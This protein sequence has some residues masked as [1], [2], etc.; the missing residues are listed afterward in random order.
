[1]A[2]RP[3]TRMPAKISR[4]TWAPRED[5]FL[6]SIWTGCGTRCTRARPCPGNAKITL[7]PSLVSLTRAPETGWSDLSLR[8]SGSGF[9]RINRRACTNARSIRARSTR[10]TRPPSVVS[11]SSAPEIGSFMLSMAST[12]DGRRRVHCRSLAGRQHATRRLPRFGWKATPRSAHGSS[13]HPPSQAPQPWQAPLS[14]RP[15]QRIRAFA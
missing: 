5:N 1:M 14:R 7:R 15:T 3:T 11:L 8:L 4:H 10:A 12:R 13:R 2:T 6:S 9:A